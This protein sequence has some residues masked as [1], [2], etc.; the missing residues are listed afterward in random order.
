MTSKKHKKTIGQFVPHT[1]EMLNSPAWRALSLSAHRI[2][3]RIEIELCRHGGRDNGKLP[4][5]YED[6]V[7]YGI[8][9]HAIAPALRELQ[10]L[11]LNEIEQQGL[12][13]NAD[14]RRS[15]LFRLTYLPTNQAP[16]TNNW[17]NITTLQQAKTVAAKART[18]KSCGYPRKKRQHRSNSQC[19]KP[20]LVIT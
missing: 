10:A 9:R 19:R 5:T 8:E 16:A 1:P 2:L 17:R 12:A 14:M 20:V 7:E 6:F 11:G 18:D 3:D 13:G 4:V 15:H